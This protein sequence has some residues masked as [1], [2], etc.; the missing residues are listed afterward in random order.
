MT[1]LQAAIVW[2]VAFGAPPLPEPA[3]R[4]IDFQ[5][6]V[7]PILKEHCLDCH[8]EKKQRGDFRLDGRKSALRGGSSVSAPIVPGKSA[9][10]P[11]IR[12]VAG[13]D[14]DVVMP[15]EDS[16][17]ARLTT[18]QVAVLRAWIDQGASWPESKTHDPLDWWS[19]RPLVRHPPPGTGHPVDAF[20]QSTLQ[21]K[22]LAAS[23]P[24]DRI[25]LIRRLF[26]D[27]HGL[28][29]TPERVDA[30]VADQ[31]PD[32]YERL[33]DELLASPRYGERWGRHW[34][35]VVGYADTHG[36]D[37]DYG[38]PN[39]WPYRDYVIRSL[40]DDKPYRKFIEEQIA[41]DRLF[42]GDPQATVALGFLAAGPW[43]DTLM[44]TVREDTVDHRLSQY[45]DR[46]NM[47]GTVMSVFQSQTVHCARCHN[48][49]F[50]PISQREYYGLQAVFAGVDR[51]ER[52]FDDDPQTHVRRQGLL[53]KKRMLARKSPDSL[54]LLDSPESKRSVAA[55]VEQVEK[56][57][58]EWT[59][60]DVTDVVSV[61][62]FNGTKFTRQKDGSWLVGGVRPDHD[63]F[64]VTARTTLKDIR[65]LRLEVLPDA[66]MPHGG[67]GR[68]DNGNFH[69][70][71]FRAAAQPTNGGERTTELQLTR[72]VADHADAGGDAASTLDNKDDTFW[73][74]HPRYN[75]PHEIVFDLKEPVGFAKGTTFTFLL[76]FRGKPGHQIGRFRL[77]ACTDS[78]PPE[79]RDPLPATLAI[80]LRRKPA[81]NE[82][83]RRDLTRL[84][85]QHEIERELSTFPMPRLVYAATQDFTPDKSF[86]PSTEP[87]PVHLL[88]RGDVNRPGE[89]ASPGTLSCLSEVSGDFRG[90]D[91]D[92][93]ARRAALAR[94][95][96]DDRNAL[97]WRSIVNRVWHFHF[98]RGQCDTPNDFGRMGGKPSH[99][100]LLDWLA[101]WFRD[102]AKGSLKS[103]HRLLLTSEA[104]RRSSNHGPAAKI[105]AD[106]QWLWR[107]NRMRL[108]GEQV[109][110][111]VLQMSGR[112]DLKSGGPSVVQFVHRG[113]ATFNPD[114]NP[115]FLDYA[116]IDPDAPELRRRS[117][118]RFV[119][120]TVPDPFM[121]ALDCPD[122][123]AMTPVRGASTTP[124][125]AFSML[126][127][128]FLIR[129]CEWIAKRLG[130][131]A[132]T[133]ELQ[134]DAAFK[135]ILHRK[136]NDRERALT[137]EYARKH[138][139]ANACHVLLNSNEF[140]YV[141]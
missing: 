68:F 117:V 42:P 45:L 112:I 133:L 32:A 52:P 111:A 34:L 107:M 108:S 9:E 70:S 114:G 14:P 96:A 123:A 21:K 129:Q 101:V 12:V 35:D 81:S 116:E 132:T 16:G 43:D 137:T 58:K 50:D 44:A 102:D 119:F 97:T 6:D 89:L 57:A 120:R 113:K 79:R 29:P 51:A 92:E 138:G 90:T 61:G 77:S 55:T 54:A 86:K 72:A 37:H 3:K 48:H 4:P 24:A 122:G 75:E 31:N 10:S 17:K 36:N 128:A 91:R 95:L 60:L 62:G 41:G 85:L 56:R 7:A 63:T 11:L 39:A 127:D 71:A 136:P 83:D 5:K 78:L 105:D 25:S 141:D 20:I 76:D 93:A 99:P 106:N 47:V 104:Y 82:I 135:L 126:N 88:Q 22:G 33:I 109:R 98:G 84:V 131:S 74:V 100:E 125:Q 69:L 40:N 134:I 65:A 13:L 67:P 23:P 110:D 73:S 124:I 87:R 66:S 59:T 49:K 30:F 28:P 80:A 46:D 1:A 19:L 94:W 27:L 130:S 103:L 140:L 53:A 26:F 118:Y 15:P 139:L 115:A 2:S 121:D 18:E 8:G 38:R 64:V